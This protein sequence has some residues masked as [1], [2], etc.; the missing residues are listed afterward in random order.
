MTKI[1][2]SE[3]KVLT[4]T[5]NPRTGKTPLRQ[6]DEAVYLAEWFAQLVET[7]NKT[8]IPLYFDDHRHLVLKGGAGSGKSVFAARKVVERCSSEA[9]HRFL[10]VRKVGK[11]LRES[12]FRLICATLENF[13][14]IGTARIYQSDMKIKFANGSEIIFVGLDNVEKLKSIYEI[15]DIWIEEASEITEK[16]FNQLDIRMRGAS[17]YYRQIIITFNPVSITHWLKRR[18]FDIF[19]NPE[20]AELCKLIRVHE[21]TYKDNRWLSEE[22]RRTLENFA[23]TDEYYYQVY[24][25]GIW[26]VSGKTVFA[27]KILTARYKKL[28]KAH[29]FGWFEITYAAEQISDYSFVVTEQKATAGLIKVFE[30]PK[31]GFPYVIGADTAGDGSDSFVAQVLDNTTGKQV[32]I[33]RRAMDEDVF[34]HQLYCLGRWYNDALVAVETNFST[35]VVRELQRLNYPRQYVRERIDDYTK[36]VDKKFG[37]RTDTISRPA[38]IAG[39]V[40]VARENP[41]CICDSTTI[42]EMLT[43]VRNE[44]TFK[45]EAEPGAHDDCVIS[46]A[47]AH[48]I[49]PHQSCFADVPEEAAVVWHKS[50]WED[51]DNATPEERAYMIKKWGRPKPR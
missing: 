7:S 3:S 5:I 42:E 45:P 39:L 40:K 17:S 14:P 51:Y 27:A 24:C 18:F 8:F 35:Y 34:A 10:C 1:K 15:T 30:R 47:I 6:I 37:F 26:G 19:D 4:S 50:M 25:L 38:I 12:S 13:Y 28:P 2:K 22:D 9:G 48:F 16:D 44:K 21:S 20:A 32:C 46:L 23:V 29:C 36:A 49:R 11:T 41:E 31:P 33:F 43:F